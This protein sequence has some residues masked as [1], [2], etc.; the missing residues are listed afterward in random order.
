MRQ[1]FDGWGV[2]T[3]RKDWTDSYDMVSHPLLQM[4]A[5]HIVVKRRFFCVGIIII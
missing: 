4:S 5:S 2:A 1:V 3:K